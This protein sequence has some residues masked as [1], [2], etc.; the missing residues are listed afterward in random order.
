MSGQPI[1]LIV[2]DLDHFKEVNDSSGHAAGDAVLIDVAYRMRKQLRAFDLAYRLG[3]EEFLVL[4]PGADLQQSTALANQL[5]EGIAARTAGGQHV[6]MSFGV[7]A[8]EN[9]A[10]FDYATVFAQAD[11]ALYEA[12]RS[13]RNRVCNTIPHTTSD[14][15]AA[16]HPVT[17]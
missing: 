5:R 15:R 7:S 3:G 12:K 8:S 9:G 16:L 6:T 17:V 10:V 1:G 14:V 13:G 11:A 2:G 4:L